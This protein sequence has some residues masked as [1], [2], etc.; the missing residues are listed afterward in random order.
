MERGETIRKLLHI[1]APAFALAYLLPE[2]IGPVTRDSVVI[3]AWIV[4]ALFEAVRLKKGIRITGLR[5]YEYR[6]P[7]AAFWM[8]SAFLLMILFF[9]VEYALPLLAGFGFVDPLIGML[10]KRGS[11]LYPLL[12]MIVYYVIVVTTMSV[13]I[14][15]TWGV[16]AL[17]VCVTMSAIAAEGI[18]NDIVDDDFL[19]LFVPLMV[20]W[21]LGGV[22]I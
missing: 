6:R 11:R 4:F 15:A 8:C 9:P 2:E 21:A 12:P 17:S 7:S 10:R 13:M 1:C 14:G 22:L 18:K 20:L 19:M 5:E 16:L 3:S